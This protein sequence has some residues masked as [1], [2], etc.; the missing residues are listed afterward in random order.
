FAL[1]LLT[2]FKQEMP[3]NL[4]QLE[5]AIH[6]NNIDQVNKLG[7]KVKSSF[8]YFEMHE[9]AQ[10]ALFFENLIEIND[11]NI[12]IIQQNINHLN[13]LVANSLKEIDENS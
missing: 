11:T 1:Q 13:Q 3:N 12:Q 8:R 2:I 4:S 9:E 5:E 7:H 6:N 10:I